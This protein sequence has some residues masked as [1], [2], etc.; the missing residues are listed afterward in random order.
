M[1]LKPPIQVFVDA[2]YGKGHYSVPHAQAQDCWDYARGLIN[3]PTFPRRESQV[4][5]ARFGL[6]DGRTRT[7]EEV[8][9]EFGV[10]QTRIRQI[11]ANGL[12]WVR[13][14]SRSRLLLVFLEKVRDN[15][16]QRPGRPCGA[17]V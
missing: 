4:L 16:A 8:G 15:E 17:P 6:K 9:R 14:P 12:R 7:L 13:Y 11:E 2:I 1:T 10:T 3:Q 5:E